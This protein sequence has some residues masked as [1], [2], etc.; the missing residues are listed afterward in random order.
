[1]VSG[2]K[3]DDV[4]KET[5]EIV[6][7]SKA[8]KVLLINKIDLPSSDPEKVCE[9]IENTIGVDCSNAVLVSA[10]TGEGVLN[11][12]DEVIDKVP[13]PEIDKSDNLKALVIDSWFDTYL[14]VVL[15]VRVFSGTLKLGEKIKE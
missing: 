10:K 15:L 6:N 14:G 9:E 13:S 2:T 1:M 5:L 12:I 4:D 8:K 11:I 7:S 3:F